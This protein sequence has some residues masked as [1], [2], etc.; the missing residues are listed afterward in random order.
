[1]TG[2]WLNRP[3]NPV[4]SFEIPVLDLDR[5]VAFYEH[6]FEVELERT[7]TDGY[8][9]ALFPGDEASPG[10]SGALAQ[11]D[12]YVP[13]VDGAILYFRVD[14]LDG[15]MRRALGAGGSELY[16]KER[17]D[18]ATSVAEIG[19]TEGNRIALLGPA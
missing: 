14:D 9:M 2:P 18:D 15:V 1:M 3:V 10:A 17:L 11:G 7:E 16:A 6:V 8:R 4:A 12:V 13:T 19:D 5:A